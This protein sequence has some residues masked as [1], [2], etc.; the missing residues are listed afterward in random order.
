MRAWQS[1]AHPGVGALRI[2]ELPRPS[3]DDDEI[4]VRV[5]SAALNFSDLLMIDGTYQIRPGRPFTPGQEIAGIVMESGSANCFS[6]GAR[7]AGKVLW[8]GFAEYAILRADMAIPLPESIDIQSAVALPVVYTTVQ[9]ALVEEARMRVG[10]TVLIHAAAGGIGLAATQ[11]AKAH[12]VRVIAAATGTEKCSVARA[13]GADVVV[14]YEKEDFVEVVSRETDGRGAAII[15][16]SV[17]GEVTLRSL[18]C[19][20][21]QGQLLVVGFSSGEIP[22]IPA[23]RLLLRRAVVRGIYWDHDRDT[24][25]VARCTKAVIQLCR[26]GALR[27]VVSRSYAFA[28]LRDALDHLRTGKSIGK[29]V[30]RT[31]EAG[32]IGRM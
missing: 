19:I 3:P 18:R 23:N 15:L 8:G 31:E 14:D 24:E 4:L 32:E 16:D 5:D 11:L 28:E 10:D 29:L 21:R 9:V 2:V 27:P 6:P 13:Q 1:G 30:L 20:A 22:R 12:G 25:M 7:V 17:G 26:A